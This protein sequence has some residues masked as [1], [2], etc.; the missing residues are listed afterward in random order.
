M[1]ELVLADG[2]VGYGTEVPVGDQS[3]AELD[4]FHVDPLRAFL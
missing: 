1:V 4:S 2:R 3:E